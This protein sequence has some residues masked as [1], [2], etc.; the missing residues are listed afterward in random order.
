M[1]LLAY[2]GLAN[3]PFGDLEPHSFQMICA[4]PPWDFSLFS[5]KG[6][7]K[8][9]QKHYRCLPIEEIMAFPVQDLA[10]ENCL[11]AMYATAPM[12]RLQMRVLD[13][14]G[15]TYKTEMV[16]RKVFE[17]G[18][19]TFGPGYIVRG[20]HEPILLATRGHPKFVAKNIRSCF[21]GIRREHSRKPEE[22]YEI[23]ER[24][25]PRARRVELF[26]RTDRP[27]WSTWVDEVGKF[28][29]EPPAELRKRLEEKYQ[30]VLP[31]LLDAA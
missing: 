7:N 25:L 22:G 28:N 21:D 31:F 23:F 8:S 15:F 19:Q 11:L 16:W 18:K 14:W 1:R 5:I 12:L 26:S 3:W 27:G 20:S 6:G 24:M 9:A 13:A 29:G 2:G 4:D 17:S 10:A 30:D